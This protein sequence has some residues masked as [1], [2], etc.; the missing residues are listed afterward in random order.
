MSSKQP[1]CTQVN[2]V[3]RTFDETL[4]FYRLLGLDFPEPVNQPPG[5]LHA[6][7]G[8]GAGIAIE[9]DNG[10][11]VRLY[12][13][14]HRHGEDD[15]SVVLGFSVSSRAEVDEIYARLVAAGHPGRQPPYDAFWGA[16]YAIVADPEGND[17]GLMSP[18]EESRKS[19]PPVNSP[20]T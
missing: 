7:T 17:I 1:R 19:W 18:I 4:G 12:S 6:T 20:E 9:I 14:G 15:S 13:A 16:R 11:L 5:A 3:A 2:I 8:L 10:H